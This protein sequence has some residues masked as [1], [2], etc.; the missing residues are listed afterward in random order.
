MTLYSYTKKK[1]RLDRK[2]IRIFSLLSI[3]TGVGIISFVL[4][5]ILSFELFY[6]PKFN[7]MVKPVPQIPGEIIRETIVGNLPRVLGTDTADYTRAS[8]WFPKAADYTPPYQGNTVSYI[9]SIPKVKIDN[10]VVMTGSDD[11]SKSLVHFAGPLPGN[12]GNTVIFGHSTLLWFYN[13]RDYKTIFSKLPELTHNDEIIITVDSV[14]YRFRVIDLRV[15]SPEDFS[16]LI[17]DNDSS[18]ITLITCVPPGT[19]FKRLAVKAKLE[20]I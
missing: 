10:A 12:P 7:G 4:Y 5:P 18:Y 19:Y 11:L 1:N 8:T 17:Q 16:P 13:P 6:A 15:I 9:L 3:L 20:N 2:I 14:T